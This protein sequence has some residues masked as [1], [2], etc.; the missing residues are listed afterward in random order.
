MTLSPPG[1]NAHDHDSYVRIHCRSAD[2]G[3]SLQRH[4]LSVT[5]DCWYRAE[6][7]IDIE[8]RGSDDGRRAPRQR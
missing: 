6:L 5:G 8:L 3:F 2:H 7:A 1:G 4:H